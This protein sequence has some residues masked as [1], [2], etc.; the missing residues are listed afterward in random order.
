MTEKIWDSIPHGPNADRLIG[1][2]VTTPDEELAAAGALF[3]LV[4]VVEGS[5]GGLGAKWFGGSAKLQPGQIRVSGL[6]IPVRT[7][8]LGSAY[9]AGLRHHDRRPLAAIQVEASGAVLEWLLPE[10]ELERAVHRVGGGRH[11][12]TLD[13]SGLPEHS[14]QA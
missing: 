13:R 7:I 12:A 6:A 4:R 3:S 1:P 5:F 2:S 10:D 11:P 14:E 9:R 8:R